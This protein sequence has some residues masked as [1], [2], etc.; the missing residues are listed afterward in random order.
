[1]SEDGRFRNA[2]ARYDAFL[3]YHWRDRA[4]VEDLARALGDRGLHVFLDRW[5]LTPGLPWPQRLETALRD[6][7]AVVVCVGAGEMGP[8]QQREAYV[9]LERQGRERA[10]PVIPVLLPG[11]EPALRFLGQL[12]WVDLRAAPGDAAALAM[13]NLTLRKLRL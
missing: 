3:S 11:A 4:Q 12:T 5:Y 13:L 9:A 6:C 7:R 8:W 10:L 2:G 1:M